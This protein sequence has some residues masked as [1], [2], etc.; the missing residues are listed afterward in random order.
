MSKFENMLAQS[1]YQIAGEGFA[2]YEEGSVQELDGWNALVTV[3]KPVMLNL[4]MD[5]Y[6]MAQLLK[7]T[8]EVRYNEV[9]VWVQEDTQGFVNILGTGDQVESDWTRLY[10]YE[11]V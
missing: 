1:A 11:K 6:A 9:L 8:P 5:E 2:I 3:S 7:E 10:N 4:G